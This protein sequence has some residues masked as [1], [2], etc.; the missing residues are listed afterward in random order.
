MSLLNGKALDVKEEAMNITGLRTITGKSTG[1]D[2]ITPGFPLYALAYSRFGYALLLL[3]RPIR[4]QCTENL[5]K[6]P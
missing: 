2:V 4:R 3:G 5:V 6:A 1:Q